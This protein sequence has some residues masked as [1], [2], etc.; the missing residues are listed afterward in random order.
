MVSEN[1]AKSRTLG[2]AIPAQLRQQEALRQV[3]E[4][5]SGELEPHILLP[6]I[7]RAACELLG[8]ARGTIGLWDEEHH[9]IR[10]EAVFQMP[11]D[12]LGAEM[13]PG[14]GLAGQVY[15][16]Q[17]PIV[18]NCY[19][20]LEHPIR[21]DMLED[22]VIGLPIFGHGQFI[23][24]LGVGAA[25]PRR[26]DERDV[27]TLTL[28][29]RHAAIALENARSFAQTQSALREME[30][31]YQTSRRISTA[32]NVDQVIEA[33]LDQ[34]AT[35]GNYTCNIVL[36]EFD[37]GGERSAVIVR[38]RWSPRE[39]PALVQERYPYTR[40]ALDPLLDAGQTVAIADVYTDARVSSELRA[41]QSQD[42]RPALAMI[43]LIARGERIGLVVLSDVVAH[44]WSRGELQLYQATAAQLATAMD[45]RRQQRLVYERG[46]QLAILEER[47]RLARELHDS[48]TQMIFSI[49]LI[50]QSLA[51]AW[52]RNPAEGEQRVARLLELSQTALAEMRALLAELRPA[53]DGRAARSTAETTLVPGVVRVRR[54]GLAA[55]L[56]QHAAA[57][58]QDGLQIEIETRGYPVADSNNQAA[59]PYEEAL[60][61]IAQ[62]ALN[63]VVKHAHAKH[64]FVNLGGDREALRM[65]IH[66]D[67]IGFVPEF[68]AQLSN[69]LSGLGLRTMP[70]RAQA[71]NG[72]VQ[73]T[74]TPGSGTTVEVV[75]PIHG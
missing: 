56:Q 49:T 18:L 7:I 2:E 1:T 5:I 61:R 74:S 60:F 14:V 24:F 30:L 21:L 17:A 13:P 31:L 71:L 43:P 73:I 40:D 75:I 15:R 9:V 54:E 58:A 52:R 11:P 8:A 22:A 32:M 72:T 38:G 59:R 69:G 33:Y 12:E 6:H 35:R 34:V 50:A 62:E 66:D 4:S 29:A 47:Q 10:N 46:Q 19:A 39:G 16:A 20:E 70:E 3:I 28:F 26:F 41:I 57:L 36:Y 23:G 64:V 67:G 37:A 45:S 63:N 53:A 55:A 65:T 68:A 51:P 48:V 25:P 44:E 27:E 42:G